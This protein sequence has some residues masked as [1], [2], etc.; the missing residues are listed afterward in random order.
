ECFVEVGTII[1]LPGSEADRAE[2]EIAGG[3]DDLSRPR[4]SGVGTDEEI[5]IDKVKLAVSPEADLAAVDAGADHEVVVATEH[6][7]VVEALQRGAWRERVGECAVDGAPRR[8][9]AGIATTRRTID[10]LAVLIEDLEGARGRPR[11]RKCIV[12]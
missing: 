5:G 6:L 4:H 8:G 11:L 3:M 9:R 7:V 2:A 12:L 1:G 10:R